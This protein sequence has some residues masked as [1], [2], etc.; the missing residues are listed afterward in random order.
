[1][2]YSVTVTIVCESPSG[3]ERTY[4]NILAN[5]YTTLLDIENELTQC[6]IHNWESLRV[7]KINSHLLPTGEPNEIPQKNSDS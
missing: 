3:V 5:K 1:M 4:H 6:G 2:N 7:V